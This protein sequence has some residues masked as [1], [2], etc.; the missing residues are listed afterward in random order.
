LGE[1]EVVSVAVFRSSNTLVLIHGDYFTLF[2][3]DVVGLCRKGRSLMA[4]FIWANYNELINLEGVSMIRLV[5]DDA[6]AH[7]YILGCDKPVVMKGSAAAGFL[8]RFDGTRP[9]KPDA[10]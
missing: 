3:R 4:H 6:M 2:L 7:A 5:V 8:E 1:V 9:P 10:G